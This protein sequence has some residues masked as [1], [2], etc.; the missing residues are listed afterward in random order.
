MKVTINYDLDNE[1]DRS[2]YERHRI[3]AGACHALWEIS[4]KVFRPARK[5]G[6]SD[7]RIEK[8]MRSFDDSEELIGLL[9]ELF[10]EILDDN[11]V[12]L[13]DCI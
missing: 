2:S 8:L 4:Q 10:F 9:E 12:G 1:E 6:Y 3:A 7:I 11:G 5:H 13:D